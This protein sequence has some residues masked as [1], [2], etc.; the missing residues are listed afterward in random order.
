M[1]SVSSHL[2]EELAVLMRFN[3]VQLVCFLSVPLVYTC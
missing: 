3:D 2:S 1:R